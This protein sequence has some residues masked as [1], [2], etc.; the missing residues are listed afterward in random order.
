MV[1][2][3]S[4]K[5]TIELNILKAGGLCGKIILLHTLYCC[6]INFETCIVDTC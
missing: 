1:P 3:Q 6:L 2:K 4:K 5:S